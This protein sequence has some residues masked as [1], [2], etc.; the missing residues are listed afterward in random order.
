MPGAVAFLKQA[1][2]FDAVQFFPLKKEISVSKFRSVKI[3]FSICFLTVLLH[4]WRVCGHDFSSCV[5]AH[6]GNITLVCRMLFTISIRKLR[7]HQHG[8]QMSLAACVCSGSVV[9]TA[10][11]GVAEP[12]VLTIYRRSWVASVF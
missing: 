10:C 12:G 2:Q 9:C 7:L 1:L 5:L 11:N 3:E 6:F 4:V 8:H